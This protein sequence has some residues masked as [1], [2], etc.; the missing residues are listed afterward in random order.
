MRLV[1]DSFDFN[2]GHV[3]ITYRCCDDAKYSVK[4]LSNY[5]IHR[6]HLID[7]YQS[8]DN[9]ELFIGGIPKTKTCEEIFD[10]MY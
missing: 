3:F 2:R 9:C 4:E 5:E 10:D 7:V 6:S 8:V 1:A